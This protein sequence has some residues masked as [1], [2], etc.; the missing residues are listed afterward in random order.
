MKKYRVLF[1]V[2]VI[3]ILIGIYLLLVVRP[4]INMRNAYNACVSSKAGYVTGREC[5]SFGLCTLD[6]SSRCTDSSP[7]LSAKNVN[8]WLPF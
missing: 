2:V 1:I 8:I 6:L 7:G 5:K 4:N 3:C